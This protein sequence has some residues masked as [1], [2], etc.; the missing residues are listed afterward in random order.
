MLSRALASIA[1]F[2]MLAH[3]MLGCC[4][5]HSHADGG[6]H[7]TVSAACQ[8]AAQR[9]VTGRTR[10]AHSSHDPH[11]APSHGR[12]HHGDKTPGDETPPSPNPC[13]LDPC[14]YLAADRSASNLQLERQCLF[15]PV[16]C[17]DGGQILTTV[18]VTS[19][20]TPR[21]AASA[22]LRADLSVWQV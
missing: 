5:H 9:D 17:S 11:H 2:S 18:V 20:A 12:Q 16:E 14:V 6:V 13:D 7:H 19:T 21:I 15:S 3:A 1:A 8:Q 10:H 22:A 4:W